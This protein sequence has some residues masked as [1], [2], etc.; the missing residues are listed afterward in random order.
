[1]S[2]LIEEAKTRG[3]KKGIRVLRPNSFFDIFGEFFDNEVEINQDSFEY[4]PK[5][6]SLEMGGY[7]I[8]QKGVWANIVNS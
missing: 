3:F 5:T 6:D 7:I 2:I 4:F 8:Y 1:M